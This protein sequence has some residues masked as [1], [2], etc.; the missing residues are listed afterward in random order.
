[1]S[2]IRFRG[3]CHEG[4]RLS[5]A[6]VGRKPSYMAHMVDALDEVDRLACR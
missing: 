5:K 1:L 6:N 2:K 4:A 3:H